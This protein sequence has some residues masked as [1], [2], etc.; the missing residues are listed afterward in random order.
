VSFAVK[1]FK[2]WSEGNYYR[3]FKLYLIA[4]K[5]GGY[6]MDAYVQRERN[7]SMRK[8]IKVYKPTVSVEKV[9]SMLGYPDTETTVVY[10]DDLNTVVYTDANKYSVD[11]KSTTVEL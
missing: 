11:C 10:L 4:P 6:L 5:M 9:A 8:L 7:M 2:S 1:V 3:F